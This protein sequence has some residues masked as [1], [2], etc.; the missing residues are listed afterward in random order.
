[1][2]R[3]RRPYPHYYQNWGG[4]LAFPPDDC[5]CLQFA[6][7]DRQSGITWLDICFCSHNKCKIAPC[8]RRKEYS[9]EWKTEN[10]RLS[11]IYKERQRDALWRK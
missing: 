9:E 11:Q 5:P 10:A 1:M 7:T 3:T 2:K 6:F 4:H 8:K